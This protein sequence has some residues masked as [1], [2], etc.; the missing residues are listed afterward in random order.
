MLLYY[1]YPFSL[2]V[3]PSVLISDWEVKHI[4]VHQNQNVSFYLDQSQMFQSLENLVEHYKRNILSCGI[5]LTR[6]CARVSERLI[7]K[8]KFDIVYIH[9]VFSNNFLSS[10]KYK[11]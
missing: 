4:K 3:I 8:V 6:P 7:I 5:C 2:C 10:V 11:R 1:L 9:H